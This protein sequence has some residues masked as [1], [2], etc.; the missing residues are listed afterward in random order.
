M[1]ITRKHRSNTCF[2]LIELL[3]V[4]AIIA[5]LASLLLPA[6]QN[7]RD[8]ARRISCA[9]NLRQSAVGLFMY[10]DDN[11]GWFPRQHGLSATQFQGIS[12]VRHL[13]DYFGTEP[14]TVLE[15]V[16]CPATDD[17]DRIA[18]THT[19]NLAST[20]YAFIVGQGNFSGNNWYGWRRNSANSQY[21][22]ASPLPN[23][24]M[25]GETPIP[26]S[27][28]K[29]PI[30]GEKFNNGLE[31]HV[32]G[33]G[34]DVAQSHTDGTNT[35]FA[36]G[37]VSWSAGSSQGNFDYRIDLWGAGGHPRWNE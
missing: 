18:D 25:V 20:Y 6:L 26:L 37:H 21:S 5:I 33:V 28:E 12:E 17:R 27:A 24:R 22:D 32:A 15:T 16:I 14:E 1:K 13:W 9:S 7:A 4:I 23:M 36:D 2:T 34:T 31:I 3:V 19:S 29:Q 8:A 30:I 10:A 35:A 11:D